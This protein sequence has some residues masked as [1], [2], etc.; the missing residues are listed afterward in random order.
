MFSTLKLY[1]IGA[2]FLALCGFAT[3]EYFHLIHEGEQKVEE[4]DKSAR[5]DERAKIKT[6]Q[7]QLQ[8]KANLAEAKANAIQASFDDYMRNHPVATLGLHCTASYSGPGLPGNTGQNIG[9]EVPGAGSDVVP[10]VSE[11]SVDGAVNTILRAAGK[12]ATLYGEYQQQPEIE[13]TTDARR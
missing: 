3:Y 8:Q 5:D 1:A 13:A 7:A 2:A 9:H 12:L 4:A 6:E 11:R 10:K